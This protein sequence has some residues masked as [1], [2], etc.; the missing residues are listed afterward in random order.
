MFLKSYSSLA[1]AGLFR[2]LSS[3]SSSTSLVLSRSTRPSRA[4]ISSVRPVRR[5]HSNDF[6]T[7]F[8]D[9]PAKRPSLFRRFI[10][11]TCLS[12]T[13]L[14]SGFFLNPDV[15]AMPATLAIPSDEEVKKL[16]EPQD[17]F[18]REVDEHINSHPLVRSLRANPAFTESRPHLKIP[19]SIRV[20]NLTAGT[21]AGPNKIVV[22]PYC[23]NE[24]GGKS[25]V[26]V[27][28]LGSDVTGHPGI[29]H[30][31]M[32]ATLLD[33][34]LA[35]CCFAALPNKVGVTANL[36]IDY[37]SPA[38]AESFFVLRATTTRVEGRKAF[39]EGRIETLPEDG[40]EPVVLVEARALFVEPKNIGALGNLYKPT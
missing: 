35:R 37:R 39:V 28:Y 12:I 34:G 1:R 38:P 14:I 22:P 13:A 25:M 16:A 27:F 17:D 29:V 23:F 40:K 33:E 20:H 31:G 26:S 5:Y 11:F 8:Q 6:P 32:L 18:A 36:Q 15:L 2:S 7:Y 4:V 19:E 30:G 24:E 9:P 3:I 21:L 10:G